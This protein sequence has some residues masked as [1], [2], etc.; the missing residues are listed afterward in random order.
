MLVW[1][2]NLTNTKKLKYKSVRKSPLLPECDLEFDHD[3]HFQGNYTDN[4]ILS[5]EI[6]KAQHFMLDCDLEKITIY[7]IKKYEQC[8]TGMVVAISNRK[9][10]ENIE[11]RIFITNLYV[12]TNLCE[13]IKIS[14]SCIFYN[15]EIDKILY[16]AVMK[17]QFW[18]FPCFLKNKNC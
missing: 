15:I 16:P 3:L 4:L 11:D 5:T 7:W 9:F 10:K 6:E 2:I 17:S 18:T 14:A 1:L 13:C 12:Y 8:K